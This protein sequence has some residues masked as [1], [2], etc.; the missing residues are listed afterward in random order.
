MFTHL[1]ESGSHRGDLARKGRFFLSTLGLYGLLLTLA[2]IASVQAYNTHLGAQNYD[3]V[4]LPPSVIPAAEEPPD[5]PDRPRPAPAAGTTDR[6]AVRTDAYTDLNTTPR[7]L[8]PVSS[9]R[10]NVPPVPRNTRFVIGDENFTPVGP[11]G[12]RRDGPGGGPGDGTSTV[13]VSVPATDDPTPVVRPTPAPTPE[14]PK[15]VRVS[16][17]VLSGK[18]THKPVPAYPAIAK[19]AHVSGPVNVEV[20]IDEQGSVVSARAVGGHALLRVA[21]EQAARQARFSPTKLGDQP[22]KVSGVITFNFVLH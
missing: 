6:V 12:P 1:I 3:I 7:E 21:A 16:P 5:T 20:L 22:V 14:R 13:R 9:E 2:G 11:P 17:G 4:F 18:M 15:Q 19:A 8:P 10:V